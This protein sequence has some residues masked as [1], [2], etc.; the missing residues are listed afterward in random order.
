MVGVEGDSSEPVNEVRQV[1]TSL[2]AV[3][4]SCMADLC[5]CVHKGKQTHPSCMHI[6]PLLR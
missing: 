2:R 1:G 6:R 4:T 5:P 3:G